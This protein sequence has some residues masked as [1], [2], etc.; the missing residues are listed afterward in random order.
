MS[1][2]GL[3]SPAVKVGDLVYFGRMIDK[4]RQHA[5]GKLP[6]EYQTNLGK[7]FDD[8]CVKFLRLEYQQLVARVK[9]GGSE[10]EIL[11]W[12]FDHGRR[13]TSH[14]I[15]YWNEFMRKRGWN[16][17]IS[18]TLK[19]RKEEANMADREE[20]ETMFAFIDADEGHAFATTA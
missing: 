9:S 7:G 19:R 20:I 18:A 4:I 12:C 2:V 17:D 5:E 15:W 8:W 6:Q 10:E 16:D 13:P 14:D 3:R 11:Q 1:N